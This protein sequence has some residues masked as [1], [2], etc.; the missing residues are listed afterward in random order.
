MSAATARQVVR[1]LGLADLTQIDNDEASFPP[2]LLY[3][4]TRDLRRV[5]S[6]YDSMWRA[7]PETAQIVLGQIPGAQPDEQAPAVTGFLA[8]VATL[9]SQIAFAPLAAGAS[10]AAAYRRVADALPATTAGRR[11]EPRR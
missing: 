11:Q 1:F 5:C 6:S 8:A 10:V 3:P 7:S 2:G 4:Y 9:H